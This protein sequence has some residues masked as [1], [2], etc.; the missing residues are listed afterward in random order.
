MINTREIID[1]IQK[2]KGKTV[3]YGDGYSIQVYDGSVLQANISCENKEPF[4]KIEQ[5]IEGSINVFLEGIDR[6]GII[7]YSHSCRLEDNETIAGL[8]STFSSHPQIEKA[9]IALLELH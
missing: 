8:F 4:L 3:R 7:D 2:N 6:D 5:R 9:L 1:F